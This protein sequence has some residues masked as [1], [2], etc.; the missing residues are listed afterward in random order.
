MD[1]LLVYTEEIS[2]AVGSSVRRYQTAAQIAEGQTTAQAVANVQ[3]DPV[4]R[5]FAQMTP[6][7]TVAIL[8][9]V[10]ALFWKMK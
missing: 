1:E 9:G 5:F 10:V 2:D 6:G 3:G 4:T 7:E 8:L